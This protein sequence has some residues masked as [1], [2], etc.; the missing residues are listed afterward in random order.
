MMTDLKKMLGRRR[1]SITSGGPPKAPTPA[2]PSVPEANNTVDA[3]AGQVLGLQEY[4][5]AKQAAEDDDS[6]DSDWD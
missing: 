6:D 3:G 5:V 1:A 4:L 2:M